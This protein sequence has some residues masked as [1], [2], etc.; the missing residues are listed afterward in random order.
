MSQ[1]ITPSGKW[2]YRFSYKKADQCEGGFR[3]KGQAQ[4]A[5]RLRRDMLIAKKLHPEDYAGDMSFRQAGEWWR[6]KR[7]PEKRSGK[8]DVGMLNLAIEYFDSTLMRKI[9][10][11]DIDTFLSKLQALRN[12]KRKD[13]R[14][15]R[16]GDHTRNHY[17]SLLHAIY[18]R[19]KQKRMYKG[20]NP[21]DF[22]DKIEVPVA[23]CR[24]MYPV[25]E[26]I[27]TPAVAMQ[28]DIFG[29]YR[30]GVELGMRIGEMQKAMVKH[31]DLTLRHVFLP[32]P[33]NNRS[34]YV[35]LDDSLVAFCAQLMAGKGPDDFLLPHWSYSYI[36]EHFY[37]ICE[38]VGIKNL[39]I[40]DWRHTFAYNYLSKG[41]SLPK[42]SKLMGHSSTD[43]TEKHYGHMSAK[44]MRDAM[45]S[46]SPFLSS[47][48]IAMAGESA[49]KSDSKFDSITR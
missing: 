45:D 34:R 7:I 23:R 42:L 8:G 32:H 30:L 16:V 40:H 38:S 24:F 44:D 17:R 12:A 26:K 13:K 46:V 22:V 20:E 31:V 49:I 39:H 28:P 9:S 1:R 14:H 2:Y 37:A 43:V 29:Y 15:Y 10:P 11:D 41:G 6:E 18:E 47:N 27:L 19:L 3:T 5:E 25:E 36:L 4:E 48:R 33:K 35:L 21:V